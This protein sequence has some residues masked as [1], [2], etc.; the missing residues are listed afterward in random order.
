MRGGEGVRGGREVAGSIPD[1]FVGIFHSLITSGRTIT[2]GSTQPVAG[3]SLEE[4][5]AAGA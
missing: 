1:G 4:A 2:L 3:V 5:K